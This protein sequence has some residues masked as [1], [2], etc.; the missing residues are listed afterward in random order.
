MLLWKHPLGTFRYSRRDVGAAD[1][2]AVGVIDR[3]GRGKE[4]AVMKPCPKCHRRIEDDALACDCGYDYAAPVS[5]RRKYLDQ[6]SRW[7]LGQETPYDA[8]PERWD[9]DVLIL[10]LSADLAISAFLILSAIIGRLYYL[11]GCIILDQQGSQ[12]FLFSGL[13]LCGAS[14]YTLRTTR[15][16]TRWNNLPWYQK[17]INTI[18]V[19]VEAL[20]F[21]L[22]LEVLLPP[23]A[24]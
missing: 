6:L 3:L 12:T 22:G 9:R 20:G 17:A 1:R 11:G 8:I 19:V 18:L 10:Y 7:C 15:G 23:G 4:E 21:G 13:V 2:R 16:L 24:N 5:R 14:L